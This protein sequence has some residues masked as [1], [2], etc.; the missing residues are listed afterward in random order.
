MEDADNVIKMLEATQMD[1]MDVALF[2][3]QQEV[4]LFTEGVMDV[5]DKLLASDNLSETEIKTLDQ[6]KALGLIVGANLSPQEFAQRIYQFETAQGQLI[7]Q[8]V[9]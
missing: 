2:R 1:A 9:R 4:P 6:A 3:S 7:Q 5:F 8:H